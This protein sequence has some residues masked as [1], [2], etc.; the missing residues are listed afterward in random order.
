MDTTLSYPIVRLIHTRIDV[1]QQ[2]DISDA[3][4]C[5]TTKVEISAGTHLRHY[6]TQT[7]TDIAVFKQATLIRPIEIE[8]YLRLQSR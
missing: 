1:T 7:M 4:L 6:I 5:A 2:L 8:A 3:S